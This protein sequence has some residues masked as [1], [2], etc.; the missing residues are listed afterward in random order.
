MDDMDDY[1]QKRKYYRLKYPRRAMPVVRIDGELFHVSEISEKGIRVVMN[2]PTTL[3]RGLSLKGTLSLGV[4]TT[5]KVK[6]TILRF[7]KNEVI[8]QLTQG[9]SFKDMVEQQR[10]IRNRYP[11]YFARLRTSAA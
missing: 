5:I 3:Y 10:H 6:G 8:L 4:E 9:P 7:D 11:V 2:N 1:V